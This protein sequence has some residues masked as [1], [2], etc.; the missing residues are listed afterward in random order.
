MFIRLQNEKLSALNS[1]FCYEIDKARG[2]QGMGNVTSDFAQWGF[3]RID[4]RQTLPFAVDLT[5]DRMYAS[6]CTFKRVVVV[7]YEINCSKYGC[8]FVSHSPNLHL[9]Q[10]NPKPVWAP[11]KKGDALKST[12]VKAG[13]QA[14]FGRR[15][16]DN[17]TPCQVAIVS[18]DQIF[19]WD[20][21]DGS[22]PSSSGELMIDSGHE[23]L[24]AKVGDP[25]PPNT[26]ITGVA[27]PEGSLFLG[28]V[29]GKFPCSICTESGCI[30]YFCY[31]SKKVQS[32]EILVL[33]NDPNIA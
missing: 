27:E 29:G 18:P 23:F 7:D 15:S 11:A 20:S 26:V 30:K 4:P 25:V 12:I 33:T 14:C 13:P 21:M 2:N 24:R 6:L 10:A 5:R 9:R 19:T 3:C 8:V 31:G 1:S 28:R 17:S 22:S 16:E 32:G